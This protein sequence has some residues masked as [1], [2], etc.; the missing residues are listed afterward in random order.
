MREYMYLDYLPEYKV[1]IESDI[2]RFSGNLI[3]EVPEYEVIEQDKKQR[4]FRKEA[5][6]EIFIIF[7]KA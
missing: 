3:E 4:V 2:T 5:M 6:H 7:L 1:F